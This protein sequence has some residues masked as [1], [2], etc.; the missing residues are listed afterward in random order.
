M[1]RYYFHL[2]DD[3]FSADDEGCELPDTAAARDYALENAR[4]IACHDVGEGGVNLDHRIEVVDEQGD[5][6]LTVTFRDAFTIQGS[7]TN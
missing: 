3:D 7:G 2:R 6:V 1:P 4:A 5:A